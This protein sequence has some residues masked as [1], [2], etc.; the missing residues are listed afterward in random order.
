MSEA[1]MDSI[2]NLSLAR[3]KEIV[4]S[5]L[6]RIV[7][8]RT[9]FK[10]LSVAELDEIYERFGSYIDERKQEEEEEKIKLAALKVKA[11]AIFEEMR[12]KGVDIE[13]LNEIHE[14]MQSPPLPPKYKKDGATWTGQ[15][16]RPAPFKDLTPEELE[17]YLINGSN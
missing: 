11:K 12:V 14:E 2:S 7:R 4:I 16:R 6:K 8:M 15:G 10:D 5:E 9:I 13:T 3:R 1:C 17:C